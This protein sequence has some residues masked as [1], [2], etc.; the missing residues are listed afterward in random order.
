MTSRRSH[1]GSE[2]CG[3]FIGWPSFIADWWA[4]IPQ[5]VMFNAC[6]TSTSGRRLVRIVSTNWE[7]R[8]RLRQETTSSRPA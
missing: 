7:F 4:T 3:I 5:T 6:A 8:G 1:S 2:Y